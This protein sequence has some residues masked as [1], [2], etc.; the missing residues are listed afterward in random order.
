MI[1]ITEKTT[2]SNL[3]SSSRYHP[4][5]ASESP[6]IR[7][8][9]TDDNATF[10]N[11]LEDLLARSG[12]F[13]CEYQF[14]SAELLLEAL[15][16]KAAPEVIL[17]DVEMGG[18]TGVDALRPIRALAPDVRVLIVTSFFDP[19]YE[20]Q[21][22]RNGASSFLVKASAPQSL[23]K[24][25]HRALASPV[26]L[27]EPA[28]VARLNYSPAILA[29]TKRSLMARLSLWIANLSPALFSQLEFHRPAA[30]PK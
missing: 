14:H 23:V 28:A 5:V 12:E 21:A 16:S 25:I 20:A 22:S 29:T 13:N 7:I 27:A 9:L 26:R 1:A 18:M 30:T 24:E 11:L 17:L 6:R 2:S 15:A 4:V 10:R 3:K 19:Q 8:W